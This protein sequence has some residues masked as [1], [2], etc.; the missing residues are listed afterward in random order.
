VYRRARQQPDTFFVGIDTVADAL[1][2]RSRRAAAKPAKG[3]LPNVLYVVASAEELPAEL[4]AVASHLSIVLP[5][6][7]LLRAV[8]LPDTATLCGL[9]RLCHDGATFE[10]VFSH[11]PE[12]D[13]AEARRLGLPPGSPVGR[14]PGPYQA[15]G[16]EIACSERVSMTELRALPSTWAKRLGYGKQRDVWRVSGSVVEGA[17]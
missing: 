16:F 8:A 11:D 5:W 9:R 15:A 17:A 4:D 1:V 7:S 2:E 14:L 3:G 10:F 6:G 12:R 13:P